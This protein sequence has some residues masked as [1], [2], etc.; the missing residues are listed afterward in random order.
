MMV[1]DG[2]PLLQVPCG[3]GARAMHCFAIAICMVCY[4]TL[5]WSGWP[6]GAHC[7][8]YLSHCAVATA[9]PIHTCVVLCVDTDSDAVAAVATTAAAAD[10]DVVASP[11]WASMPLGS[12]YRHL[13]A[14]AAAAAV[15]AAAA[16]AAAAAT[17]TKP[18]DC[19]LVESDATALAMDSEQ[20]PMENC[21]C[22]RH[23]A[24]SG[25]MVDLCVAIGSVCLGSSWPGGCVA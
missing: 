13:A 23:P 19:L 14:A 12:A 1:V 3:V 17:G 2:P 25:M 22:S 20:L 10:D 15:A 8:W 9:G 11:C 24:H 6:R 5:A 4:P 21:S 18:E 16:A 7:A